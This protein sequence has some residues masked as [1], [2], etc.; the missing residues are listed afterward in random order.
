MA[1]THV[2]G[3]CYFIS[4]ANPCCCYWPLALR[5][6]L[7]LLLLLLQALRQLGHLAIAGTAAGCKAP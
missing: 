2:H 3:L 1:R 4:A 5:L 7:L 6:L